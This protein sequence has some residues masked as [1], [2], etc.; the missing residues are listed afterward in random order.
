MSGRGG[1]GWTRSSRHRLGWRGSGRASDRHGDQHG[2]EGP[3][4]SPRRGKPSDVV[5]VRR[6]GAGQL[7]YGAAVS[8]A[9]VEAREACRSGHAC[10]P[11]VT[12]A[13]DLKEHS[14][15]IAFCRGGVDL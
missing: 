14:S 12:V 15:R 1:F 10:R 8:G 4:R 9:L 5:N 11:G 3:R 13:L 6:N 7:P 2:A